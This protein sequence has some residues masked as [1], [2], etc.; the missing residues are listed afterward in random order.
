MSAM[1]QAASLSRSAI[2]ASIA[3]I[4]DEIRGLG[5]RRLRLFGSAARDEARQGSDIDVLVEFE[6]GRKSYRRLLDL[7]ELLEAT[8]GRRVDLVTTESL[9]PHV[10][11]HI[12]A[13][14]RDVLR[15]A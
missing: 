15:L 14:A 2:E 3:T 8:L 10:G 6:P 1:D 13:E 11:P 5:V 4:E 7:A 12:L 9:S